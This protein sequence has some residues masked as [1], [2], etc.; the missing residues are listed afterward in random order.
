MLVQFRELNIIQ[1]FEKGM[2][3]MTHETMVSISVVVLAK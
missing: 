2:C 1:Q 3:L